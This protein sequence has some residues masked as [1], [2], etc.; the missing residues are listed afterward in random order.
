MVTIR[1]G[2]KTFLMPH[3]QRKS[4]NTNWGEKKLST[5]FTERN[6][7]H[8]LNPVRPHVVPSVLK[9]VKHFEENQAFENKYLADNR[10]FLRQFSIL[11]IN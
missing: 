11:K 2:H 3:L 8:V 7:R 9:A 10:G 4:L 1:E 6:S 5:E